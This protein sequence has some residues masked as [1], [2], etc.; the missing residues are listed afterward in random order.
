VALLEI[1]N[2]HVALEDGTEIVKGVDLAVDL[3]EKHAIMGPNGSGK[4]T[5]AYALMGHP[6]YEITQGEILLEG[7]DVVQM[8]ADERAKRGLFLAFQYPHA[9]PGVTVTNFLRQAI[10][11]LR[12]ARAGEDD[13][14]SIKEFR[15][16]LFAAMERLRVPRELAARYLND[17]FSGGEKKRVEILQMAL[18]KPRIAVLDETDSGLD[19]DALRIVANGVNDLV[20]P[21]MGALVITHY[22]RILNYVKPD[23]VHVF[24][25]GRIVA[26]GGPELAEQLEA[27]GYDP[28]IPATVGRETE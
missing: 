3:N 23:F 10:N 12:K 19:I 22:Q 18:L 25:D 26:E 20:G 27:E 2:L 9:I 15:T 17:G 16:E 13:P 7:E 21:E 4:S 14:I 8:G 6:A 1:N 24:V 5:L 11:A 28:F